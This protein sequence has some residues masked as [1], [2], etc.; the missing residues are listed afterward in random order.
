MDVWSVRL[1]ELLGRPSASRLQSNRQHLSSV[2]KKAKSS[3][4]H[5]TKTFSFKKKQ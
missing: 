3:I 5:Q 4:K 1:V 2:R